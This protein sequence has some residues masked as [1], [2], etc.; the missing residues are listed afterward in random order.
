MVLRDIT[1]GRTVAGCS[2]PSSKTGC[3]GT[4][5][6]P[7]EAWRAEPCRGQV[8]CSAQLTRSQERPSG[9]VWS[10]KLHS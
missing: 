10:H 3:E 8:C 4:A 2:T 9:M 1:K 6:W 5:P 7:H